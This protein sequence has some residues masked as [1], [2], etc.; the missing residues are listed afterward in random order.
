[1]KSYILSVYL[2]RGVDMSYA[3]EFHPMPYAMPYE[4]H[5]SE[6]SFDEV[7]EPIKVLLNSFENEV[8]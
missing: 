7:H 4:V 8:E 6:Y 3:I 1:M 5:T 2:T